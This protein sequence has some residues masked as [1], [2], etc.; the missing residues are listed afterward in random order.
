MLT[1]DT[2]AAKAHSSRIAAIAP[3]SVSVPFAQDFKKSLD[4]YL[5]VQ[6]E[7]PIIDVPQ[8]KLHPL[9]DMFDRWRCASGAVALSPTSH[10]RL[11]VM[12]KGVIAYD[13]FEMVVVG[14]S[15]RA[16]PDQRHL[17]LQYIQQ[18]SRHALLA[19]SLARSPRPSWSEI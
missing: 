10:A 5:D 6:P 7:T 19:Q 11:D 13:I 1:F 18:L 4:Q 3:C 8:I 15:V 17:T 9:R 12:A 14:Q 16:R 2:P